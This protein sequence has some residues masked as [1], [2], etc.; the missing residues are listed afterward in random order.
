MI[1][2]SSDSMVPAVHRAKFLPLVLLFWAGGAFAD[3]VQPVDKAEE[4]SLPLPRWS[5]QELK[6]FRESLPGGNSPGVL[7]PKSGEAISDINELIHTPLPSG[8]RLDQFF[9]NHD[10]GLSPRLQAEDIRLFLPEAILGLPTQG[11]PSPVQM[12]TPLSALKNVTPEF[13][14]ACTQSLPKE[15]LIDPDQLVPEI[16]NHDMLRLLAFHAQDARIK[17]YLLIIG[18]D[19]KL[20]EG[21]ELEKIASGSLLK[22]DACLVVYPLGEP[23]RTRLFVSRSIHNQVS[24]EFLSETIQACLKEALQTSNEHDQLRRYT[25]HLSTRLFWLQKAL[26]TDLADK[27]DKGQALAEFSSQSKAPEVL[28]TTNHT[29]ILIWIS[30]SLLLLGLVGFTCRQFFLHLQLRRQRRVWM[31]SE[32][33]TVPRLG[34]AFTGGGGRMIRYA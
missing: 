1:K 28:G 2:P 25:I 3:I 31:L 34:G 14:A 11:Q 9:N 20:P 33:E 12:P 6:I 8:P 17:L 5:E 22:S 29:T 32:P 26:V 13:L 18:H 30:G 7:P 10:S 27:T 16:Q 23:W 4:H 21:A 19:Q 15:Y 24:S